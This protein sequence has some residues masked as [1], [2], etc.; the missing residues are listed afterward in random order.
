MAS[1]ERVDVVDDDDRVVGQC[2]RAQMRADNLLHRNV[3]ILCMNGAGAIYVQRRTM[4][5]DLFPGLHDMFVGGVVGAGEDYDA[6]AVR[7]IGE[8]LGLRG[9]TPPRLCKHRYEGPQTRS[10]TMAYRVTWDGP[11]VHQASEVEWGRYCTLQDIVDNPEGFRF[12]PDNAEVFAR[13]LEHI[14]R[15][16]PVRG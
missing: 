6:A 10:H 9:P 3:A 2:T 11:I 1:E 12:V 15:G 7:E 4:T 13:Y 8:E 14:G 5:K 16:I